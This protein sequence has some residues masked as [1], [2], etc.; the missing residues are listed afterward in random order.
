[1]IIFTYILTIISSLTLGAHFLREGNYGL[2]ITSILLPFMLFFKK[3]WIIYIL[4]FLLLLGSIEWFRTA[5]GIYQVRL[6]LGEPYLRMIII[7]M[8]V[9]VITLLSA[10]ML[11]NRKVLQKYVR[12]ENDIAILNTF[13][14]STI[15]IAFPFAKIN[16]P[17]LL[18]ERFLPRFGWLE[19]FLLAIYASFIAEQILNPSKTSVWRRRIWLIFSIIFFSQF[20]LGLMGYEI[21]LMTGKL[22]LPVPALILA[23]PIYRWGLSFMVFLF[24]GSIFLLG[25]AWCSYLCYFGVWDDLASRK[26]RRPFQLPKYRQLIR[27][28]F[29]ILVTATSLILNLSG[30]SGWSA[31]VFGI[32]FGIAGVMLMI[33]WSRK[34]GV[35][36]HCTVFCPIGLLAVS[37]GK[38]SPFR[39]KIN[40]TCDDC[41]ICHLTCRYDALNMFDIKKR[42]PNIN[43]T[44]CGDCIG[45]C[46][47]SSIEYSFFKMNP[48]RA[49]KLF[50]ILAVSIHAAFLGIGRI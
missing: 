9:S 24:L 10:I 46:P 30:V 20:V 45:S 38:I 3:R 14:L 31:T 4:A 28:G 21:F 23:G 12:G 40:N 8:S 35:M 43:C 37:L 36:T 1:M 48:E 16:F 49:R 27:I 2:V 29:L 32:I 34:K 17:V 15:L 44:L 41:A 47:H 33:I 42:K 13:I 26:K 50:I 6:M 18:L 7:M 11:L 19:V 22:H 25:P 5:I 39:I